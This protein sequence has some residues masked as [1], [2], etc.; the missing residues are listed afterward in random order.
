MKFPS[1]KD[2]AKELR[3]IN[4][5]VENECEVRL[6][7]WDDSKWIIRSGDPQYDPDHRGYWGSSFVP[8]VVN[9]QVKRF[10]SREIAKDLL[11][12]CKESYAQSHCGYGY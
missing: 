9:G 12:D 4:H 7:V 10:N 5:N 11:N 3:G 8:G 1:I 6:Q 2:V